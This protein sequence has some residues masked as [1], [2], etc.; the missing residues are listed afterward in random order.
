MRP[1]RL[2]RKQYALY[3]LEN[4]VYNNYKLGIRYITSLNT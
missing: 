3:E 1:Y 2:T 4:L